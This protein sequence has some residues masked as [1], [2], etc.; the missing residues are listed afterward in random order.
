MPL[1]PFV[2]EKTR[3][4]LPILNAPI[5]LPANKPLSDSRMKVR[6][7]LLDAAE[8][9]LQTEGVAKLQARPLAKAANIAVGSVYNLFD[10][11]DALIIEVNARTLVLVGT[12]VI[13]TVEN[14]NA[15]GLDAKAT[16]FQLAEDYISFVENN[17]E[18][19]EATL[20]S[21]RA[22]MKDA[23]VWYL[24]K[25]AVLFQLISIVLTD[26][27]NLHPNLDLEHYS[28]TM[29][30]TV[31]GL[32]TSGFHGALDGEARKHDR[33]RQ[34]NTAVTALLAACEHTSVG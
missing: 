12:T 8:K 23:P 7:L 14:A 24:Q 27:P 5:P 21:N 15:Q 10:D 28:K 31:N 4:L 11:L 16:L 20:R 33:R 29:W 19:W 17:R 32:V 13:G 34:V 3:A 26:L 9:M 6:A 18:R 30:G 1:S 22:T 25:Q 2:I